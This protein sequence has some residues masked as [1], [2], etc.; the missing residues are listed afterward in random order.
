MAS[1]LTTFIVALIVGGTVIAGLIVGAQREDEGR[2]DLIITNGQV[3]TGAGE[4]FAEAVAVQGNKILRVGSNREIKRMRRPQTL[5]LDAH[6]ATVLPGLIDT[7]VHL[8]AA[9][10][11]AAGVDLADAEGPEDIQ[12]RIGAFAEAHAGTRW[13]RG[14]GWGPGA[15]PDSIAPRALLDEA[16]PERPAYFLSADG[17][18]AWVNSTALAVAGISRQ[19]PNPRNGIIV[20]DPRTGEP[21]GTLR[22]TAATLVARALPPLTEVERLEGLEG[23]IAEAHRAGI[24]SVHSLGDTSEELALYDALRAQKALRLRVYS[25]LA[26]PDVSGVPDVAALG[27]LQEQFPDDPLVKAGGVFVPWAEGQPG[28]ASP[29]SIETLATVFDARGWQ[30]LIEAPTEDA[31]TEALEALEAVRQVNV[32]REPPRRNRLAGLTS[33]SAERAARLAELDVI[34]SLQAAEETLDA[35]TCAA[36]VHAGARLIFGSNWPDSPVNPL[37]TLGVVTETSTSEATS[38]AAAT[39]GIDRHLTLEQAVEAH[40]SVAAWSSFDEQRKGRLARGLLA[41]IVILNTDLFTP[42]RRL[43]DA[44][45]DTTIFDGKVVYSRAALLGT[46]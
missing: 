26:V 14:R 15:L 41:D 1:R 35:S 7:H 37:E 13:V 28:H 19:T 23:A 43:S 2:V 6:G 4:A 30:V 11:A 9:A 16:L 20:R 18:T 39:E 3:F 45:V 31:A 27:V 5:M 8:G 17:R 22:D 40:T 34:A 21:T 10:A 29:Q 46:H 36:A 44:E 32:E 38:D 42:G 33:L 24:T 12:A 25:V